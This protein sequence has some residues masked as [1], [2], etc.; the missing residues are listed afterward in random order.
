MDLAQR[1]AALVQELKTIEAE[2]ARPSAPSGVVTEAVPE[3]VLLEF[4]T[5]VDR[6]RLI[7]WAY[8]DSRGMV[9][10]PSLDATLQALRVQRTTEML[11]ALRSTLRHGALNAPGTQELVREVHALAEATADNRDRRRA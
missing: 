1:M 3:S 4:K 5:A 7:L 2:L 10:K 6:M 9:S 8:F 11:Q